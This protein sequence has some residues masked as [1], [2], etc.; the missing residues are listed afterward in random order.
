MDY[1]KSVRYIESFQHYLDK[2]AP[3]SLIVP[4]KAKEHVKEKEIGKRPMFSHSP[5][6]K[7]SYIYTR[8]DFDKHK[9]KCITNGALIILS[10]DIIVVDVDDEDYVDKFLT[11]FPEFSETVS[12]KTTKGR[13]FYFM[14]TEY[15][16]AAGVR[17]GAKQLVN[18]ETGKEAPVDIKTMSTTGNGGLISIPPSRGKS[19]IIPP[20]NVDMLDIPNEFVDLY[21]QN[22]KDANKAAVAKAAAKKADTSKQ[23]NGNNKY[24]TDE[25][26]ALLDLLD[27][28]RCDSYD[29]WV[30]VGMC[31]HNT[32]PEDED[33]LN[34][35]DEWS[36]K[37]LKYCRGECHKKWKTFG[38]SPEKGL[39]LG[40]LHAWAKADNPYMY[41]EVLN[42]RVY[43][44]IM[45]CDTSNFKVAEIAAKLFRGRFVCANAQ[46]N[47]WY[48][49]DGTLW[50]ADTRCKDMKLELNTT[51]CEQ[52][53][54]AFNK[55]ANSNREEDMKLANENEDAASNSSSK[56]KEVLDRISGIVR[57][58]RDMKFKE[59]VILE[60]HSMLSDDYFE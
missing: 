9:E 4:A 18:P 17:D 7:D 10:E 21:K 26:K 25:I 54:M 55:Y 11:E 48:K 14:A 58:L 50:T 2:V 56:S 47:T 1:Y 24:D 3:G 35:W 52:F 59:M 13:H 8:A 20:I 40:S 6:S 23:Q 32:N 34:L 15:S 30:K 43:H 39:T 49:F 44:K 33:L 53:F 57:K 60:M 45:T 31:L 5:N 42:A 19:W 28:E 22:H 38:T 29:D 16:R 27:H 36:E 51:V 41:R 12:T 37:S 46:T